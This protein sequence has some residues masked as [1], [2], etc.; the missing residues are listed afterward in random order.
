MCSFLFSL[1]CPR[2]GSY[3]CKPLIP[4]WVILEGFG[5]ENACKISYHLE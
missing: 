3:A 5:M 1:R 2:D 4:I